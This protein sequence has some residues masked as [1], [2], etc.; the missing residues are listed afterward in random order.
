MSDD[1]VTIVL[2]PNDSA[3][4]VRE[5]GEEEVFT[6]YREADEIA[7]ESAVRIMYAVMAIHD[8]ETI[9]F[10]KGQVVHD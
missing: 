1:P 6:P 7:P 10:I 9:E 2:G 4:V 8:H 5:S 3:L